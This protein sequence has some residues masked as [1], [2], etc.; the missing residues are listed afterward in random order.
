MER[1]V[2]AWKDKS[3]MKLCRVWKIFKNKKM[4]HNVYYNDNYDVIMIEL[5]IKFLKKRQILNSLETNRLL[6]S[7]QFNNR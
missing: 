6:N 3:K 4:E 7:L 5:K 2:L 1:V